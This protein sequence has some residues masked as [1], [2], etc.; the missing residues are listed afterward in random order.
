MRRGKYTKNGSF[1]S[2]LT[3]EAVNPSGLAG[4]PIQEDIFPSF[5]V[6]AIHQNMVYQISSLQ[7]S[8]RV[9]WK[10]FHFP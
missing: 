1:E 4:T 2:Y 5:Q 3:F 10:P 8:E 9:F 7:V 6:K